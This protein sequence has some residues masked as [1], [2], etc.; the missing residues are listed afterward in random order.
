VS[1]AKPEQVRIGQERKEK[2]VSGETW[3]SEDWARKKR[4][5]SQWRNLNKWG[6]GKKEEKG[7]SVA[8]P[9]KVRIG[10]KRKEKSLSL[11]GKTWTSEDWAKKKRKES[12]SQWQNLNK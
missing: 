4:K 3:T 5:E 9:E 12:K 2:S 6:L 10:Q 7:V 8:K 1:V 11:S